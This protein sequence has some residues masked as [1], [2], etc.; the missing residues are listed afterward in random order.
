MCENCDTEFWKRLDA[1]TST[2]AL[3]SYDE[4][5]EDDEDLD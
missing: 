3:V 4:D 1:D 5:E 2:T